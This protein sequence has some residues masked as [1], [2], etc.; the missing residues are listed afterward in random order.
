M[1]GYAYILT[2]PGIPCVFWEH[3]YDWNLYKEIQKLIAVRKNYGLKSTSNIDIVKA[4]DNLYAAVID[5][6]VA[7]KLGSRDWQPGE[8]F[9]ILASGNNYAVWGRK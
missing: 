6:K 7:V 2:H 4:E 5:K 8:N 9:K 3:V 1:Q